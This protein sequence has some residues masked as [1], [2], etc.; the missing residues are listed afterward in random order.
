MR[1]RKIQ[2]TGFRTFA[3]SFEF[4]F[5]RHSGLYFL[6]GG[7][8]EVDPELGSNGVGKSTIWGAVCWVLFG[9]TA[10]GL[11]AGEL[12]SWQS[13]EKGYSGTLYLGRHIL[14]RSW[15]PNKLTLD[16]EVIEQKVLEERLSLNFETFTSA[17]VIS[18]GENMFFDLLPSKKLSL[19]TSMLSLDNWIN[20]SSMAKVHSDELA[21]E[22]HVIERNV[23]KLE[24]KVDGLG[25]DDLQQKKKQW[26]KKRRN[27]LLTAGKELKSAKKTMQMQKV[28]LENA[29]KYLAKLKEDKQAISSEIDEMQS[30]MRESKDKYVL[31]K[32]EVDQLVNG[33]RSLELQ[34]KGLNKKKKG[35]CNKCGQQINK[36]KLEAFII[37]LEEKINDKGLA[38]LKLKKIIKKADA[39]V[40]KWEKFRGNSVDAER[41]LRKE[42]EGLEDDF[43]AIAKDCAE[44]ST[45]YQIKKSEIKKY[46]SASNPFNKLL[47][48]KIAEEARLNEKLEKRNLQ[49]SKKVQEKADVSYWVNGFKDVRLYLIEEALLQLEI[50]T[51]K[52]LS[53]LGFSSK[54]QIKYS[55]DKKTKSGGSISGFNVLVRSPHNN[56]QVPFAAWSGG[57]KQRLKIAGSMGFIALMS[58]RTGLDLGI[59][60]YDE[61]TQGLSRQGIDSLLEALRSRA[62]ETGKRIWLVDQHTLDYGDF[63]GRALVHKKLE[64]SVL[65]QTDDI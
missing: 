24:G 44:A 25:I 63:T 51:N 54:W 34:I 4:S 16:G 65:W 3:E 27:R 19:F 35:T 30:A 29:T 15:K 42:I 61:P 60:V 31:L 55:I 11:K 5:G 48:E 39:A 64:G 36:K 28:R 22:L 37:S 40:E 58:A 50:E 47:Q 38:F 56:E 26:G 33:Q 57:E 13:K 14:K 32:F 20:Y 45:V 1:L 6:E 43:P 41:K 12:K 7:R 49:R 59:E 9:K 18:Q 52:A 17:V 2:F 8:N 62:L 46:K 23:S 21:D 53:S 10:D